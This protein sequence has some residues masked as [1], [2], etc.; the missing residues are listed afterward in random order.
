[1]RCARTARRISARQRTRSELGSGRESVLEVAVEGQGL[2]DSALLHDDEAQAV[3]GAVI[4]IPVLGEI[5]E[6]LLLLVR[7]R[8]VDPSQDLAIEAGSDPD[9]R[10]VA[11]ELSSKGN[12]LEDDVIRSEPELGMPSPIERF[13]DLPDPFV[14]RIARR[15]EREEKLVSTKIIR[16]DTYRGPGRWE[17]PSGRSGLAR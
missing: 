4:L 2:L 15:G 17:R 8:S 9:R 12:G 13:E 10:S 5:V 16:G 14:I 11:I 3:D 1:M 7:S 6:G